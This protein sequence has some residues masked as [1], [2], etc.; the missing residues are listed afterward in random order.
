MS[1]CARCGGDSGRR[2][3]PGGALHELWPVG[4]GGGFGLGKEGRGVL[5][6]QTAKRGLFLAVTL[7]VN[8]RAIR[9]LMGLP[10]D[11]LHTLLPRW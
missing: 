5:L 2:P 9:R 6:H 11:G 8:R 7:V 4:A 3:F 1:Y 10:A